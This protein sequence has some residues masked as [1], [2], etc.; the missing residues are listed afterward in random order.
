MPDVRCAT[1]GEDV[2]TMYTS[3][4]VKRT[5][6]YVD[7][8]QADELARRASA[9][10]TTTSHMIRDAIDAYL[11]EPD[12]G[13]DALKRFRTGLDAGFGAATYLPDG[14]TFVERLRQADVA[15]QAELRERSAG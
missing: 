5:Q 9:R 8:R 10:G 13:S 2:S 15:R 4:I 7:E 11:A 14:A 1:R 6:I 12:D 3:Y